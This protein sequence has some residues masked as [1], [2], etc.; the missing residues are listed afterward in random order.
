MTYLLNIGLA[1]AGNSNIGVGTV[2]RDLAFSFKTIAYDV[3]Y[4]ETEATVVALVSTHLDAERATIALYH[5]AT[6]LGKDCIAVWDIR[7]GKGSLIGPYADA[8]GEFNR[9][10]FLLPSGGTLAN[11]SHDVWAT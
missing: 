4:S 6:T 1:R 2:L 10:L 7:R 3:R 11:P 8:C 5:L 9:E